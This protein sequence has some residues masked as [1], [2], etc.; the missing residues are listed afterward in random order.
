MQAALK[1]MSIS[2][3]ILLLVIILVVVVTV[4]AVKRGTTAMNEDERT[5]RH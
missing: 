1:A 5:G 3:G 4:V 2:G